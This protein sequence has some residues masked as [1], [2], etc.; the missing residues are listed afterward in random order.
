MTSP[1]LPWLTP[2]NNFT[3]RKLPA[4]LAFAGLVTELQA[5]EVDSAIPI[6]PPGASTPVARL[7]QL[8]IF[9]GD[10]AD[11]NPRADF[12]P[13][14][15]NV[16]LYSDDAS[17]HRFVYVPPGTSIQVSDD[18]WTLPNGA[19]LVK[20]FFVPRDARDP[21][22]GDQL[23]ETR[24]LVKRPDGFVVSTYLWNDEQTDA[25][26]SAGNVNIPLSWVDEAGV[27]HDDHFHVPGTSQ[28]QSCH[29]DRALGMTTR[30]M[31]ASTH[32]TVEQLERFLADDLIDGMPAPSEGLQDPFGEGSLD[33]RARSYLD[34]NC[35]SCHGD[36]GSAAGTGLYWDL[37]HTTAT[38]L[39]RCR[40]TADVDGRDRVIVPG[41]PEQSAV[42]AR[43]RS[44]D[45]FLR[46][47][48]G[49][50]HVP[51]GRGIAVV[52]AW[53]ESLPGSCK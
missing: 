37:E 14:E 15:V 52:S 23:L 44:S 5:C 2:L 36:G 47:P 28:C 39:P 10:P 1:T 18:R 32:G 51:D 25:F 22:L 48:R 49:P 7:S 17:K 19:Y 46:M 43:M 8:G 30:Q 20:T 38:N 41:H 40:S 3:L 16:P 4:V 33:L 24:F 13:Y 9:L 21:S 12:H 11:Q 50:S 45:P 35:S 27:Q 53:I 6:P 26:A 42:L 34:A 31:A 29:S